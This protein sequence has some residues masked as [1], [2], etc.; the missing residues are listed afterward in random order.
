MLLM[1]KPQGGRRPLGHY[2]AM[3][4]L[5]AKLHRGPCRSWEREFGL[6]AA[7]SVSQGRGHQDIVWRNA[8]R[9]E[10]HSDQ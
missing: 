1:P 3:P 6:G 7:F 2:P 5:H 9:A 8:V 10:W 4:R